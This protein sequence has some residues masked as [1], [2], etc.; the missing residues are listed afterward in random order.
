MFEFVAF[1]FVDFD[2]RRDADQA[3]K[4]CNGM[5]YE[6]NTL[7]VEFAKGA[8]N[9]GDEGNC[10]KCGRPGHWAQVIGLQDRPDM[11]P[12]AGHENVRIEGIGEDH[13]LTHP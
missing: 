12:E 5:D 10:F 2:E 3:V 6:G 7:I 9:K 11:T 13:I 4:D 8:A 1:G